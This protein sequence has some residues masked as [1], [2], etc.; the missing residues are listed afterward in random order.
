MFGWNLHTWTEDRLQPSPMA[1]KSYDLWPLTA[2]LML[3]SELKVER[4]N[5]VKK[6]V[7]NISCVLQVDLVDSC[8]HSYY[9]ISITW[10]ITYGREENESQFICSPAVCVC[11]ICLHMWLKINS[12]SD[13]NFTEKYVYLGPSCLQYLFFICKHIQYFFLGRSLV[14]LED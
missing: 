8:I 1:L 10:K 11:A 7:L 9:H 6:V 4:K 2:P 5:D 14:G 12:W 3:F 13:F